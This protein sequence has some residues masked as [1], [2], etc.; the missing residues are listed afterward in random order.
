MSFVPLPA[1]AVTGAVQTIDWEHSRIHSGEGY[2]ANGKHSINNGATE[3]FLLKNAAANY[4]H[5]RV[6]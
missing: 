2:L 3:Y 1:D 5:L 6:V 4:P